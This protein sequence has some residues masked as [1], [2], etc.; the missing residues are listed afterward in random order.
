MDIERVAD[1]LA[2]LY[3][4]GFG[5]K[6]SGRYRMPQKILRDML[7]RR[8]LYEAD[9]AALGRALFER[10]F[11]LVDMD[12]FIVVLSANSFVNYRRVNQESLDAHL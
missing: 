2:A 10:G 5:G 7:G 4:R 1:Q 3:A 11:V 6:P 8:R 9:M 12:S